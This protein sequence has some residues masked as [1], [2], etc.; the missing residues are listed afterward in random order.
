M[1]GTA[2]VAVHLA[3]FLGMA[4]FWEF[5]AWWMHKYVMHGFGWFLHADHHRPLRR[6]LQKNDAYAL[7]F[8]LISFVLIYGGL[9]VGNTI[10]AAAGL[11]IAA[12]GL[13]YVLFH[14]IL[15][16]K[17]VRWLRLKPRGRYLKKLVASHSVH[18]QVSTKD[19]AGNFS[20]LWPAGGK[21][22]VKRNMKHAQ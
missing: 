14:E 15:F 5:V 20:F 11:G 12:Y 4:V 7:I 21:N 2:S 17:R 19:G 10:S 3:V 16:H 22:T 9:S 8:A 1:S 13:C 18:H 6:G